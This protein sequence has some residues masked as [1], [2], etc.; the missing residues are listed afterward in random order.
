MLWVLL[1]TSS[2]A[3]VKGDAPSRSVQDETLPRE[4]LD[5][6]ID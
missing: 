2:I 6:W 4:F 5:K 3:F 1:L